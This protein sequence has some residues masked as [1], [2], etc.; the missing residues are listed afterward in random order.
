MTTDSSTP[1]PTPLTT[2][3]ISRGYRFTTDDGVCEYVPAEDMAKL[4]RELAQTTLER[5]A[6]ADAVALLSKRNGELAR[7][8][9]LEEENRNQ[10]AILG[11]ERDN[12]RRALFQVFVWWDMR[13]GHLL[14]HFPTPVHR[15]MEELRKG[16]ATNE[17]ALRMDALDCLSEQSQEMRMYGDGAK[18]TT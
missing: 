11:Y 14:T 2:A 15:Q 17:V 3:A 6:E 10:L 8:L 7:K 18:V 13:D 16:L 9:F 12:L 1:I 5:N 4:E